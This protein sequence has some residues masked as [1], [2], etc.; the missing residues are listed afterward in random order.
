MGKIQL[1]HTGSG[2]GV[3]LSSDGTNL[4]LGGSAIGGGG[5]TQD[6]TAEGSI[7]A[8]KAV[9]LNDDGKVS[10]LGQSNPA[11][12]VPDAG[13]EITGTDT[14][15]LYAWDVDPIEGN[16]CLVTSAITGNGGVG[17]SV[18]IR[19]HNKWEFG[20]RSLLL[21]AGTYYPDSYGGGG[22]AVSSVHMSP[23]TPGRFFCMYKDNLNSSYVTVKMGMIEGNTVRLGKPVVLESFAN[24]WFTGAWHP[25]DPNYIA[26][27]RRDASPYK[28][29]LGAL[30]VDD[31]LFYVSSPA[32]PAGYGG[33][34]QVLL[35]NQA[36]SE[37]INF[38][39]DPYSVEGDF[40]CGYRVNNVHYIN[41]GKLNHNG[42][43]V[44]TYTVDAS[45]EVIAYNSSGSVWRAFDYAGARLFVGNII[46]SSNVYYAQ[47]FGRAGTVNQTNAGGLITLGTST[48]FQAYGHYSY[49]P[50]RITVK[51]DNNEPPEQAIVTFNEYVSNEKEGNYHICTFTTS[52]AAN[53]FTTTAKASLLPSTTLGDGTMKGRYSPQRFPH[54]G[55][56]GYWHVIW[57]NGGTQFNGFVSAVQAGGITN[58]TNLSSRY[59]GISQGSYSN[60]NTATIALNGAV[61][62]N[63]SGLTVA[64]DYFA[65]ENGTFSTVPAKFKLKIG[66]AIAATKIKL[67]GPE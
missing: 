49:N 27:A 64:S 30:K 55:D 61:D 16:T 50:T 46:E 18:G 62:E 23:T 43:G 67:E 21:P 35:N 51:L 19:N 10:Q 58:K 24:S 38:V 28:L 1:D 44:L 5:G 53:S 2:G 48:A 45:R 36:I 34:T 59:I 22:G 40:A 60:G 32:L 13:S 9:I 8:G 65:Q 20:A 66:K 39:F 52:P 41:V 57:R 42:D 7:A 29:K 56:E 31:S 25:T 17:V 47:M 11:Q 6:F 15:T 33:V 63:Q 3:T 14:T 26:F 12:E 37:V 4:L 54:A